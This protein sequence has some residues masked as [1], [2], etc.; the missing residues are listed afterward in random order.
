ME[1]AFKECSVCAW[2]ATCAKRFRLSTGIS[3]FCEDFSEDL[4]IKAQKTARKEDED[5]SSSFF[6]EA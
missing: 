2:R 5:A 3:R 1:N 4:S 6:E